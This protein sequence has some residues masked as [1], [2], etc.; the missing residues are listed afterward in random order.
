M[1]VFGEAEGVACAGECGLQVAQDCVTSLELGQLDA[2]RAAAGHSGL[3]DTGVLQ[4]CEAGQSIRDYR[5]WAQERLGRK[6]RQRRL[7]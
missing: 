1:R 2:G 6:V 3:M 4:R 5:R 7:H